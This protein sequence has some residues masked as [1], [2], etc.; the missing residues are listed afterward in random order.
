MAITRA[1]TDPQTGEVSPAA[2]W[3]ADDPV[4]RAATQ[5]VALRVRVYASKADFDAGKQPVR[6]FNRVFQAA[7][8]AALRNV[9]L[10][11]VEP[12]LIS[13]FLPGGVR[14]PD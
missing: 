14:V 4:L 6:V 3:V 9:I 8:Y 10:N 7:Q 13:S 1:F 5:Q 11:A 2:H 12:A